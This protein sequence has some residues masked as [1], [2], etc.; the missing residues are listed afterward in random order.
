MESEFYSPD[1]IMAVKSPKT[2]FI[3]K[4]YSRRY[5][6]VHR[7]YYVLKIP[8]GINTSARF[9]R[10][11]HR[12]YKFKNIVF[13]LNAFPDLNLNK[14]LASMLLYSDPEPF[15]VHRT[16]H[17]VLLQC[18]PDIKSKGVKTLCR[19]SY[20]GLIYYILHSNNTDEWILYE[21][22]LRLLGGDKLEITP[23][24]L[25]YRPEYLVYSEI[26]W[27]PKNVFECST[28]HNF[29]ATKDSYYYY[30]ASMEPSFI[31]L[32]IDENR[33]LMSPM[34]LDEEIRY[35]S[36]FQAVVEDIPPLSMEIS[37]REFISSLSSEISSET[38]I[39]TTN[40]PSA[41]PFL[42]E[43]VED[44]GYVFPDILENDNDNDKDICPICLDRTI[45]AKLIP[46]NHTFCFRCIGEYHDICALCRRDFTNVEKI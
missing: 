6:Y 22:L 42:D 26:R 24:P 8:E 18:L 25:D 15:L 12:E 36:H 16:A 38:H 3:F 45:N 41:P 34:P 4:T 32:V 30:I 27:M 10:M 2:G 5:D 43:K 9:E 28:S 21:L 19:H 37:A 17:S 13:D 31:R 40:T 20:K 23:T 1:Q 7:I 35:Q 44:I 14:L 29:E 33:K 46:C 11:I 39:V